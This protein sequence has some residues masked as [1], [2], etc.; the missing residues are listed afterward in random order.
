[1]N[2]DQ[3]FGRLLAIANVLGDRV[4]EGDRISISDK[5]L[6][7]FGSH[8][9]K[10]FERIHSE[11][12]EYAPRFRE[13]ELQ[14]MEMFG[15]ILAD[16]DESEF[17]NESLDSKYLHAY[18]SQQHT[19]NNVI[20]V[21][22]AAEM[23]NLSAGY[24]KNLCAAGKIEAKKIGKTWIINKTKL[25]RG[26]IMMKKEMTLIQTKKALVEVIKNNVEELIKVKGKNNVAYWVEKEVPAL[27]SIEL[28]PLTGDWE[29]TSRLA[30]NKDKKND[31]VEIVK[32]QV[33]WNEENGEY[34]HLNEEIVTAVNL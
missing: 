24:I 22:E 21:E 5:Y 29:Y 16:M 33:V 10:A 8:P 17:N 14:L 31:K 9:A 7:K 19:L 32:Y 15:E 23:L 25:K 2:R 3:K 1:M 12:M 13:S 28:E 18:Y 30:L 11:L 27:E 6:S 20:G 4:F 34:D 26:L